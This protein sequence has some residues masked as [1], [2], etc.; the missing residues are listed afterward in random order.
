MFEL[1]QLT[2]KNGAMCLDGSSA[3][4]YTYE[5]DDISKAPNKLILMFE[6]TDFGWCFKEDLSSS[7]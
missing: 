3:A 5:P 6:D 7:L 4:I 2:N 1:V